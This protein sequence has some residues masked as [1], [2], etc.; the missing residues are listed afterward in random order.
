MAFNIVSCDFFGF[1]ITENFSV[2]YLVVLWVVLFFVHLV[3]PWLLGLIMVCAVFAVVW[4]ESIGVDVRVYYY[5][6]VGWLLMFFAD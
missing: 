4:F 5:V 2:F 6:V 1:Y 3:W